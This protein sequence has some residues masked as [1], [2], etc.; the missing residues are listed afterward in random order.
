MVWILKKTKWNQEVWKN[1][2]CITAHLVEIISHAIGLTST[3]NSFQYIMNNLFD[4]IKE[5]LSVYMDEISI[6]SANK[7]EY[8]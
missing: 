5:F 4:D 7:N 8:K 3:P 1:G 2:V 6:Q